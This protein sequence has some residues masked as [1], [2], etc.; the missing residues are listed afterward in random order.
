[1]PVVNIYVDRHIDAVSMW[2]DLFV[3]FVNI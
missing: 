3:L 2:L 1:M